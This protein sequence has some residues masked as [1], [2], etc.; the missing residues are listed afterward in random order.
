MAVGTSKSGL[1]CCT[2]DS[3]DHELTRKFR[4]NLGRGRRI[5]DDRHPK[6]HVTVKQRM[7]DKSLKYKPKAT[8]KKG[9]EIYV[10]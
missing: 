7:E 2:Y 6:F 9:T 3:F 8:W 10:E 5:T 1:S 4:I